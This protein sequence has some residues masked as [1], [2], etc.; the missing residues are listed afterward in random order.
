MKTSALVCEAVATRAAPSFASS[1][2]GFSAEARASFA[3]PLLHSVRIHVCSIRGPAADSTRNPDSFVRHGPATP[4][5]SCG[6]PN[7]TQP[8]AVSHQSSYWEAPGAAHGLC[9]PASAPVFV[10]AYPAA[11]RRHCRETGP[12]PWLRSPRRGSSLRRCSTGPNSCLE[13]SSYFG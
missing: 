12:S 7:S 2:P 8:S 5:Y 9:L 6:L 10:L 11:S 1:A 3:P 13:S 4:A